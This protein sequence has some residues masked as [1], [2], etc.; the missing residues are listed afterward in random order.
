[1]IALGEPPERA[2]TALGLMLSKLQNINIASPKSK[3]ALESIGLSATELGDAVRDDAQGAINDLFKRLSELDPRQASE[4]LNQIFGEEVSRRVIKLTGNFDQYIKTQELIA[5]RTKIAGAAAREQAAAL[6]STDAQLNR[7]REASIALGRAL[8]DSLSPTIEAVASLFADATEKLL[9]FSQQADKSVET[10]SDKLDKDASENNF[11]KQLSDSANNFLLSLGFTVRKS[12]EFVEK[13]KEIKK[14]AEEAG[15]SLENSGKSGEVF[16]KGVG[17]ANAAALAS[18]AA[19]GKAAVFASKIDQELRKTGKSLATASKDVI[20][21]IGGLIQLRD[22]DTLAAQR[23]A[24]QA[25]NLVKSQIDTAKSSTDLIKALEG[26]AT[27]YELGITSADDYAIAI[28]AADE[29]EKQFAAN[30]QLVKQALEVQKISLEELTNAVTDG[31]GEQI[32]ASEK[33]IEAYGKIPGSL[34]KIVQANLAQARTTADLAELEN[35]LATAFKNGSISAEQL[36]NQQRQINLARLDFSETTNEAVLS[37]IKEADS[38]D[39]VNE[40]LA[41]LQQRQLEGKVSAER[42]AQGQDAAVASL[43]RLSVQAKQT[44]ADLDAS[45][46]RDAQRDKEIQATKNANAEANKARAQQAAAEDQAATDR[47]KNRN[48]VLTEA[49]GGLSNIV[50]GLQE[51]VASLSR[52][53]IIQLERVS[54][55]FRILGSKIREAE[56]PTAGL[57]D[58]L[59]RLRFNQKLLPEASTF[60]KLLNEMAQAAQNVRIQFFQQELRAEKLADQ[61]SKNSDATATYIGFIETARDSLNLL[62]DVQLDALNATIDEA[63]QRLKTIEDAAKAAKDELEGIGD[64]LQDELDR[65]NGNQSAIEN[66][67]FQEQLDKISELEQQGGEAAARQAQTDRRLAEEIHQR[68]LANIRERAKAEQERESNQTGNTDVSPNNTQPR[69]NTQPTQTASTNFG[70]TVQANVDFSGLT[71]SIQD[72]ANRPVQ[73]SIDGRNIIT[74]ITDITDLSK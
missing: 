8:G 43:Q 10:L 42:F 5:D 60:T 28:L 70:N 22:R 63:R 45:S 50:N 53:A 58:A 49:A 68:K 41:E 56:Q 29:K 72:L 74:A 27:S 15:E 9:K 13:N 48:S 37:L 2:A 35:V 7:A 52:N 32:G 66:R 17:A 47:L 71:K 23:Q 34:D 57:N 12:E 40:A 46:K 54:N 24:E 51:S 31:F 38:A 21:V 39:V 14:S 1:L 25:N 20:E 59:N 36:A 67:R 26:I 6:D 44:D 62:D 11:F 18:S 3:A 16:A 64:S 33:L 4:A 61:L 65:I 55:E 73:F 19:I 69:Q 30:A